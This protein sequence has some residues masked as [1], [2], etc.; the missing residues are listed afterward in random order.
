MSVEPPMPIKDPVRA[1]QLTQRPM[2][3]ILLTRVLG[4]PLLIYKG[5]TKQGRVEDKEP[6]IRQTEVGNAVEVSSL[7]WQ[8]AGMAANLTI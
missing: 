2:Y 4:T 6:S 7:T 3:S 1:L 8:H 5:R